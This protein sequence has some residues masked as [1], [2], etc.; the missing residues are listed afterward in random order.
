[1]CLVYLQPNREAWQV[2]KTHC[3]ILKGH[4]RQMTRFKS[5]QHNGQL[6]ISRHMGSNFARLWNMENLDYP[7]CVDSKTGYIY[8][9]HEQLPS[10]L[11]KQAEVHQHS[12]HHGK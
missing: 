2:L 10:N 1:M 11:E 5:N 12:Q 3:K 7:H 6:T 9:N 4:K 8:K